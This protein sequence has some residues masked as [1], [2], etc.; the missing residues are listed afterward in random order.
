[1]PFTPFH[2][3][4][5]AAIKAVSGANFSLMV[6]GFSQVAIDLEP[7]V[8]IL[9]GDATLHGLSH[10]YLGAALIA[11]LSIVLGKPVCERLLRLW[12]G[13]ARSGWLGLLDPDPKISWLAATTGAFVGTFS[14]VAIDSIMHADMEPLYPVSSSNGLLGAISL[15]ELHL[16][17]LVLGVVGVVVLLVVGIWNRWAIDAE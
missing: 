3:G 12:L 2:M 8:R 15:G 5:G 17:C 13:F 14:H 6:F 11:A 1:M 4:P 16:L 7:L 10:T 9:R